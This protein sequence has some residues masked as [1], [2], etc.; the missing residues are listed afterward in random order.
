MCYYSE[1]QLWRGVS[2][3]DMLLNKI[4]LY[5][6]ILHRA[7]QCWLEHAYAV[8]EHAY[9]VLEHAY[10]VLE[11]EGVTNQDIFILRK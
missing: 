11:Q 7:Y 5:S 1:N 9:A 3:W 10:A 2:N 4:C 8:L 6:E